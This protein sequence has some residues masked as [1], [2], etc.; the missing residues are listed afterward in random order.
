MRGISPIE[1]YTQQLEAIQGISPREE[2]HQ[3]QPRGI[4]SH[5]G[6]FSKELHGENVISS[7]HTII[8]RS[9]EEELQQR[10]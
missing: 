9:T 1:I 10:S 5:N 8:P 3:L 6:H 4:R 7:S 2:Y